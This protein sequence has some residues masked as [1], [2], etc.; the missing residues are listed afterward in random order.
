MEIYIHN[1]FNEISLDQQQSILHQTI[2]SATTA[3][4]EDQFKKMLLKWKQTA[5]IAKAQSFLIDSQA[6]EFSVSP[7]LQTWIKDYVTF[8]VINQLS[9]QKIAFVVPEKKPQ[10]VALNWFLVDITE[11]KRVA[12]VK[13]FTQLNEAKKW[14]LQ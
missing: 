2:K 11:I 1:Q 4:S 7:A 9:I 6:L 13:H 8:P 12:K 3:M 14:L 5:L 10:Q